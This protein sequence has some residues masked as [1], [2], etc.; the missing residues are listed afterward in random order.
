MQYL[1]YVTIVISSARFVPSDV[2]HHFQQLLQLMCGVRLS[3]V[4]FLDCMYEVRRVHSAPNVRGF[5]LFLRV[6][7]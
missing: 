5:L 6:E 1:I 2:E 3:R 4:T 7:L